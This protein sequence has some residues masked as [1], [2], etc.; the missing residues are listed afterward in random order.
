MGDDNAFVACIEASQNQQEGQLVGILV[1]DPSS[2][3]SSTVVWK[4][5]DEERDFDTNEIGFDPDNV[6]I[7]FTPNQ[8][9]LTINTPVASDSS[10]ADRFTFTS[11]ACEVTQVSDLP[12]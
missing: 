4:D 10:S 8:D 5:L 11:G 12:F 2:Q 6:E 9:A 1:T 7:Q 3:D